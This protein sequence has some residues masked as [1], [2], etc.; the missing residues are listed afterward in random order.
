MA[1]PPILKTTTSASTQPVQVKKGKPKA[2]WIQAIQRQFINIKLKEKIFFVQQL[3]IMIRT[4]ISMSVALGTLAEQ[5]PNKG[6][7]KVL[8][9]LQQ[10]IEKGNLLSDGL[11]SYEKTFGELFIN[12]V[13][14]GEESGKLEDVLRQLF[15]QMKKDSETIGKV[16]GAM[17]Y[18]SIVVSLMLVIGVLMMIYVI[19]NI[20]GIFKELDVALPL[21]TRIL[22]FMSDFTVNHGLLLLVGV[23]ILVG[24]F[25][26]IIR[27]P[28]GKYQ[29][30]RIL[31]KT[32]VAGKIIKK[33]NIAR[34]CRT[35][36][37]LLKTDIPIVKSFEITA[38]ILSNR[39]YREALQDAKEKIKKGIPI[40]QSLR[41]YPKLFPPVVLQ[42]IAVGEET[43]ALDEIL[44]ESAIFYEDE[45]SETMNNLP[46][47][48]E[49]LLMI[50]LGVGVGGM[51]VAVI[52]P[53]YSLT[54]AF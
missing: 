14:A 6:F 44:E 20:T 43:G 23:I 11:A 36:G 22:I 12:M 4:G 3:G 46:T 15:V 8:K 7:K 25:I 39:L 41:P 1:T 2:K 31:L 37:S 30:H 27:T 40:E 47:I 34:F 50:I 19:P 29:F 33:I 28:K 42:M 26:A 24:S 51:A 52:M 45:V 49:P 10:R 54:N 16:K 17:I 32:P 13:R 5:T 18:P 48:M 21:A 53:L 35:I 38:R 9:D